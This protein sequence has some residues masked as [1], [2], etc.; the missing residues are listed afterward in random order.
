MISIDEVLFY[1]HALIQRFGGT[2][3]VR[4]RDLLESAIYRPFQTF[5]GE[6]LYPS[7]IHKAAAVL[8][9]IV[10]NHPFIDGNKRTGYAMMR[11]ILLEAGLDIQVDE[12]EKY[13]FVISIST[14][15]LE[16]EQIVEWLQAHTDS[17]PNP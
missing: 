16:Y 11:L 10:R 3:G 5:G 8:E 9:S 12:E 14:G 4:S 1:H 17:P 6:D 7:A 15:Q 13:Q 2:E